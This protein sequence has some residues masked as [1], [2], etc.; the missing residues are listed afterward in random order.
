VVG[1]SSEVYTARFSAGSLLAGYRLETQV[2]AG[3]MAV[4]FRA[5]DERL[6]R[7]VALKVLSPALA[8]DPAF[9]RRFLAESRAAAMV[10]DPHIIPVFE[11]GDAD[12]VLF[13]AMRFVQGG[14]LR[15]VLEREGALAA[16]RAAEFIFPVAAALDAAHAA[17]TVHRDVKPANILVD[18]REGRPDHV[19]LSDFGI[20]KALV[21][22]VSLT[23]TGFRVGTP[24]YLAP[25]Q[26]GGLAVDGRADQYALA[27]VAYRLL[28]GTVP[29]ER[30]H[31]MSVVYAHVHEPVPPLTARRPDLP[32]AADQV[33]A[34]AMAKTP[35][36][37]FASCGDFAD[38]LGDALGLRP[39][40]SRRSAEALPRPRPPA[41][42]QS[43]IRSLKE[44]ASQAPAARHDPT[45]TT[46]GAPPSPAEIPA[47][48][49]VTGAGSPGHQAGEDAETVTRTSAVPAEGLPAAA[50][51]KGEFGGGLETAGPDRAA[52]EAGEPTAVP[53]SAS[54]GTPDEMPSPAA[55]VAARADTEAV[56]PALPP[57]APPA[58]TV[59]T[60]SPASMRRIGQARNTTRP[61]KRR[62]RI[63][64]IVAIAVVAAIGTILG[65][66]TATP[67]QNPPTALR[68]TPPALQPAGLVTRDRTTGSVEI[69]WS[70]PA[71]GPVP[72]RY[73][74]FQDGQEVASIPGSTTN[75]RD[76]GLH[77]D[78]TYQF[79]I[80][81]IRG[82]Q[83][84]LPSGT[85]TVT[86]TT[87]PLSD[88]V[89]NWSGTVTYKV[90]AASDWQ[91]KVGET[92]L[93]TWAFT[94]LCTSG[95][96]DVTL[97]GQIYGW[98]FTARLTRSGS[99]YSGVAPRGYSNGSDWSCGSNT[100][101]RTALYIQLKAKGAA[102]KGQW[103]ITSFT[104]TVTW[105]VGFTP[106]GICTLSMYKMS[107]QSDLGLG[108]LRCR[109][110]LADKSAVTTGNDADLFR[111]ES[112]SERFRY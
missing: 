57:S 15:G 78:T 82:R 5:R 39:Y 95:P 87:P 18:A 63:W 43:R 61:S 85:L 47:A 25:E 89:L 104:G 28:T 4:V 53:G 62:R 70:G 14:D 66:G 93:N 69:A 44:A 36:Q 102:W 22:S 40:R 24:D 72:N 110:E 8:S 100:N 79:K 75:Y 74:V 7:L 41:T 49:R 37:R 88:A 1:E 86:T 80:I 31:A 105:D 45:V 67:R 76:S 83:R 81:A 90:V 21:A 71:K 16:E 33:V 73:E 55:A 59:T 35:D 91:L 112:G 12:G 106:Y 38:A 94:P 23:E 77:P 108:L 48:V 68:P 64:V 19:Y 30:D 99:T 52:G 58:V 109:A 3:G 9:R 10:D 84:S 17:G 111:A 11:A 107:V 46:T 50:E 27:C 98:S 96:C 6:E 20:A 51:A 29:Y 32:G 56:D 26:I 54:A 13:I 97:N 60:G 34:K 42:S 65:L 92:M 2:G 101:N 103:S